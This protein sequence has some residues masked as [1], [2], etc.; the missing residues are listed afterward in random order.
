MASALVDFEEF[1]SR[2][3]KWLLEKL[4]SYNEDTDESLVTYMSS[5]VNDE[6]SSDD[7]KKESVEPIL[8]EL[9]QVIILKIW[10]RSILKPFKSSI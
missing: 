4:K 5:L 2:F 9:N 8:E 10:L 7:D 3:E 1:N 6:D